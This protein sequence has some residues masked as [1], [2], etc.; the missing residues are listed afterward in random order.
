MRDYQ[1]VPVEVGEF[2]IHLKRRHPVFPADQALGTQHFQGLQFHRLVGQP[3]QF[4]EFRVARR[5]IFANQSRQRRHHGRSITLP[6]VTGQFSRPHLLQNFTRLRV[7]AMDQFQ[8]CLTDGRRGRLRIGRQLLLQF[9]FNRQL[10]LE[11]DQPMGTQR[12]Q[13]TAIHRQVAELTDFR[14]GRCRQERSPFQLE[15]L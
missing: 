6:Q 5:Q 8:L 2:R 1:L 3:C 7:V 11:N 10:G 13:H 15:R 9:R 12:S 4:F 14:I